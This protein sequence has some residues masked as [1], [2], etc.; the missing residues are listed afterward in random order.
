MYVT[1]IITNITLSHKQPANKMNKGSSTIIES[2]RTGQ[3]GKIILYFN[4]YTCGLSKQQNGTTGNCRV[5][6]I[7][8]PIRENHKLMPLGIAVWI[9]KPALN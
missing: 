2:H 8:E 5:L 4:S 6:K 1:K 3:Y 9:D 7:N